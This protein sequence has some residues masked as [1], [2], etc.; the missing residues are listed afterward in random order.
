MDYR[1]IYE[2][3]FGYGRNCLSGGNI[4]TQ[5]TLSPRANKTLALTQ[6]YSTELVEM[7]RRTGTTVVIE[8]SS[9]EI[10][11][12]RIIFSP[13]NSDVQKQ[14]YEGTKTILGEISGSHGDEYVFWNVP[15]CSLV[16]NDRRFRGV[17]CVHQQGDDSSPSLS[18]L[19]T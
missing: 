13:R 19:A 14:E 3:D 7:K 9:K 6:Y 17:Y 10:S 8:T 12:S 18:L 16:D 1:A 5:L 15:P 11:K 4:I 2:A